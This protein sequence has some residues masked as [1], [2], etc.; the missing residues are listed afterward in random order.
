GDLVSAATHDVELIEYFFAHTITP[1]LVAI[2]VPAVVLVVLGLF[3]GAL[4][5]V[6]VPFLVYTALVPILGRARIDRLGL[7]PAR[8]SGERDAPR[9]AHAPGA[10]AHPRGSAGRPAGLARARGLRRPER[11]R[12]RHRPGARR[13]RRLSPRARL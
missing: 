7:A 4:V 5:L 10:R 12:R 2:L 3:G 1:A 13:D 9:L 8:A 6:L 11:A